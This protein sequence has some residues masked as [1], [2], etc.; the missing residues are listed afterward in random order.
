MI[1]VGIYFSRAGGVQKGLT[2]LKW[3]LSPEEA[4]PWPKRKMTGASAGLGVAVEKGRIRRGAKLG[5]GGREGED[6]GRS[7]IDLPRVGVVSQPR[8]Q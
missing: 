4:P 5:G 2:W 8:E 6:A 1:G 7:D 3:W